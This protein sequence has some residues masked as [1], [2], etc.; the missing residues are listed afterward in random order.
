MVLDMMTSLLRPETQAY[1]YDE[2]YLYSGPA[3]RN[4][5]VST[6]PKRSQEVLAK[7]G[8]PEYASLIADKP[9]ELPLK[10]GRWCWPSNAGTR[11][12]GH[13]V[14]ASAVQLQLGEHPARAARTP[15]WGCRLEHTKEA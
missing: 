10:P 3:V 7:L 1:S 15:S 8:R 11:R 2:G 4:V 9:I 14:E 12:S 5:P 6:A 13:S